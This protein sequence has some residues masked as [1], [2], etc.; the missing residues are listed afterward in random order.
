MAGHRASVTLALIVAV[1]VP[2]L[3]LQHAQDSGAKPRADAEAR[4]RNLRAYTEL[5]RSDLR[6]RKV[7]LI[8]EIMQFTDAEDVAFWPIYREYEHEL[9]QLNDE[10][11]RAFETYATVY[12]KLTPETANSLM[13]KVLDL[14]AGRTALKQKFFAKLKTA[15]SPLTAARVLQ[16]ENQIGLIVDLQVASSLPVAQ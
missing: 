2:M 16:I 12:D 1:A 11:L 9:S 10:R 14:E 13:V 5:L 3:A 6:T 15:V 4:E 7:A 8:T